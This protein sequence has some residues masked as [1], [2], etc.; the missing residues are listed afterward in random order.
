MKLEKAGNE[1]YRK[2]PQ[3]TE[4]AKK[5]NQNKKTIKKTRKSKR[6]GQ[7]LKIRFMINLKF[8]LIW[9]GVSTAIR[10]YSII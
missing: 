6:L 1:Q 5:Q 7:T 2:E 4:K 10:V 9:N 3:N 8:E